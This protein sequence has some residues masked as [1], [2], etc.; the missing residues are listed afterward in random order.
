M[1]FNNNIQYQ[2]YRIFI[3]AFHVSSICSLQNFIIHLI[4]A[5]FFLLYMANLSVAL[6][7]GC[8]NYLLSLS[9]SNY[10][11]TTN[12][13]SLSLLWITL[14][15]LHGGVPSSACSSLY[16]LLPITNTCFLPGN[17]EVQRREEGLWVHLHSCDYT[18]RLSTHLFMTSTK[19]LHTH[20]STKIIL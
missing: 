11:I 4:Q 7:T 2:I 3:C 13:V 14:H 17:R 10:F 20:V 15:H 12:T 18:I 9:L 16:E 6:L 1:F 8:I 19:P 5:M